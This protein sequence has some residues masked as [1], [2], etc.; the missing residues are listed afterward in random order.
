[1]KL[2]FR[3]IMFIT[4]AIVAVLAL[5]VFIFLQ[6]P[7][8][9]KAPADQRLE[10]MKKSP[11][12]RDGAFDNLM[13]T[14]QLTEGY[15]MPKILFDFFFNKSKTGRPPRPLPSVKT[16]LKQLPPNEN[17]FVWFGHSSY[18]MQVDGLKFL[19]DPVFSNNASPIASSNTAFEG[20]NIYSVADLPEIDYLLISHDH[21]DHLDYATIKELKGKVKKIVCGLG[22]GEHLEYWGYAPESITELDWDETVNIDNQLK[23][24]ALPARHF[25]G[26]TFK[27]NNTLWI[28]ML[29]QTPTQKIL[30]GGDSGFGNHFA[31]IGKKFAPIDWAIM[32]N[33]QYN[34]AWQAI[35]SLPEETL[36][37][38]QLLQA[39]HVIPVH[40]SKF[41]LALHAWD[42]PLNEITRLNAQYGLDLVTPKIGQ[43]VRF[44]DEP[45]HFGQWWKEVK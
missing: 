30:V 40:S 18:Y 43:V 31:E 3:R 12:Y 2:I 6:Q 37:A 39:K 38:A 10:R 29:L 21:Y 22:V 19:I 28:A 42:E 32:E 15:S 1:M 11:H 8:F 41:E 34:L 36:K 9:G 13:P 7:L 24:H 4:L 26:R 25:S 20:T 17:V 14:P 45:Q 16:D 23:I 5:A 44:T 27:R 35:H 33:G